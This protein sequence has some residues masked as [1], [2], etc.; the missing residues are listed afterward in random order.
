MKTLPHLLLFL[1]LSTACNSETTIDPVEQTAV[2]K[3]RINFF[4]SLCNGAFFE[5]PCLNF[6]IDEAIGG[7]TWQKEAITIEGFAFEFGYI[8]ELEVEISPLD[9][10]NCQDDCPTHR[11]VVVRELSKTAV[12]QDC[13]VPVVPD[14]ICIQLYDPVCGCDGITYSNS[15]VAQ[16]SG[17]TT[18]TSD[19]CL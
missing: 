15:C 6:Q 1:L 3:M 8:Y 14:Q 16:N 19:V 5:R 18:W 17:V 4:D 9:T 12:E 10:T 11:Y 7:E 2:S 13:R